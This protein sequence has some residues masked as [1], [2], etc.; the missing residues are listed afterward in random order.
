MRGDRTPD[1]D[2]VRSAVFD[3]H[4]W[5]YGCDTPGATIAA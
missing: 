1:T 2:F 5:G 3:P 4:F